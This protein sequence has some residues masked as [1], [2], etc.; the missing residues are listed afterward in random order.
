MT[1][2]TKNRLGRF[3]EHVEHGVKVWWSLTYRGGVL[4]RPLCLV[5]AWS[6]AVC[7]G[8]F[9]GEAL[10]WGW[11]RS[12][13]SGGSP[14]AAVWRRAN[15]EE[16]RASRARRGEADM[17][18]LAWALAVGPTWWARPGVPISAPDLGRTWGVPVSPGV[19]AG[20][21]EASWVAFFHPGVRW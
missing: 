4:W 1:E 13:D 19:W 2:R 14:V 10:S 21:G 5:A 20:Y 15:R 9:G 8:A 7:A 6:A 18:E 16:E 11:R 3:I 12:T 17:S